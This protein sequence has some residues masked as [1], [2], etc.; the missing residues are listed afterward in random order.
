[1]CVTVCVCVCVCVS[2]LIYMY[3]QT[4]PLQIDLIDMRHLPDG[5][6]SWIFHAVDHWSKFNFAYGIPRKRA[7]DVASVLNTHYISILWGAKDPAE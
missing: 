4:T 3:M 6:N 1:M 7:V 5:K 2:S